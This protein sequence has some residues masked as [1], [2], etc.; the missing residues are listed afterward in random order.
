MWLLSH[1]KTRELQNK[2]I[3]KQQDIL[4][5]LMADTPVNTKEWKMKMKKGCHG[6]Q[7]YHGRQNGRN[8]GKAQKSWYCLLFTTSK[9]MSTIMP[10][11]VPERIKDKNKTSI[12]VT[13]AKVPSNL[14]AIHAKWVKIIPKWIKSDE[15]ASGL[16]NNATLQHNKREDSSR[17]WWRRWCMRRG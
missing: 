7:W 13:L 8:K 6:K 11:T 16:D 10:K 4:I 3:R 12:N 9:L 1:M 5:I 17:A 2:V 15:S 14:C